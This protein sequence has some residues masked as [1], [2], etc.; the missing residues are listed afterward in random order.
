MRHVFILALVLAAV[1]ALSAQG[2]PQASSQAAPHEVPHEGTIVDRVVARIGNDVITL[3]DERELAAYQRLAGRE[4][5]KDA[6]LLRE[7]IDQWV[8]TNDAAAARFAAPSTPQVDAEFT[9][10]RNQVGTPEQFAARLR[11]LNLSE[12]EV[13]NLVARQV[14]LDAYLER[15]FRA[16]ARLQ[17]GEVEKY[18]DE[19]F[20][21]Q[22]KR[23]NQNVPPLDDVR[24]SITDVLIER[25]I[26][27][28]AQQWI[29]QARAQL[30][31]EI[32]PESKP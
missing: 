11:Q 13:R 28:R 1:P 3:S 19:E 7:L 17:P 10:L 14:F 15:K 27:R 5:A 6:E 4:P 18:Y 32:L 26:T 30:E 29:D 31:I 24:D 23:R 9:A 20:A 25:D 2:T 22:L 8:V 21:P 12:P 16:V